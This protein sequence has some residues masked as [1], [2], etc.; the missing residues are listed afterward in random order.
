MI[1]T[2]IIISQSW[3]VVMMKKENKMGFT[4]DLCWVIF[5]C[6]NIWRC[7]HVLLSN[8]AT[9]HNYETKEKYDTFCNQVIENFVHLWETVKPVIETAANNISWC[10]WK[11]FRSCT[12]QYKTKFNILKTLKKGKGFI[13][14]SKWLKVNIIL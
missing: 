3:I 2:A 4:F 12:K 6:K 5:N 9:S 14:I 1:L 8:T 7:L 13:H 11:I 10:V